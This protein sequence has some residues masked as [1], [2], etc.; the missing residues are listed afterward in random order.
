MLLVYLGAITIIGKGPTY[1]GVPPLYWGEIVMVL[2]LVWCARR[3]DVLRDAASR[4]PVLSILVGL[5]MSIGLL[6]TVKGIPEW[7]LDAVRDAALWYYGFFFFVGL[8]LTR[9]PALADKFWRVLTGI[10]MA[11]LI[12]GSADLAT[13]SWL[14]SQGPVI[15]WRGVPVLSNTGSE[16]GQNVALG[17]LILLS[18][19]TLRKFRSPVLRIGLA[20]IGLALFLASYGRGQKVGFALG[21]VVVALLT[22]G[23]RQPPN[24]PKRLMVFLVVA[25]VLAVGIAVVAQFDLLKATQL[26]R[27]MNQ[28]ASADEGTAYWRIIWWQHLRSAVWNESPVFGLGFGL[29]LCIYNPYLQGLEDMEWVARS[30]HNVNMTV[31]SRMGIVGFTIWALILLIGIGSLIFRAWHGTNGK[32]I[33]TRARREELFFWIVMLITTWVNASFGVLME[34]P[35]LGIWFWFALGFA[36]GRSLESGQPSNRKAELLRALRGIQFTAKRVMESSSSRANP[37]PA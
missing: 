30:P 19:H 11:A 2:L 36:S 3:L 4:I 12:W 17:A 32:Q 26:D 23:R 5:F 31:F 25:A 21:I 28:D 33:Y 9:F 24:F 7:Q 15:P 10:W 27:F 8:Y 35:V 34:G 18:A 13:K 37:Y 16:L 22:F 6:L 29:N 14:S 20:L 1:L